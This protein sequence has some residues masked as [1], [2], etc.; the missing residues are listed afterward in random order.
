MFIAHQN[1]GQK[2]RIEAISTQAKRDQSP[3]FHVPLS[4]L[5]Q[6]TPYKEI[7]QSWTFR[8]VVYC[9]GSTSSSDG[10][11]LLQFRGLIA[12][13]HALALFRLFKKLV[14]T[15]HRLR[16]S[17]YLHSPLLYTSEDQQHRVMASF[18]NKENKRQVRFRASLLLYLCVFY[19]SGPV[20]PSFNSSLMCS[21]EFMYTI[22]GKFLPCLHLFKR[23]PAVFAVSSKVN[24]LTKKSKATPGT[25]SI[26]SSLSNE[27]PSSS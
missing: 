12:L 8:Q 11:T 23:P 20:T 18:L 10:H 2:L 26:V 4:S 15:R 6:A 9:K 5:T 24:I 14:K 27:V 21:S 1:C 25:C 3:F 17:Q 22:L 16:P 13:N 19:F 7:M